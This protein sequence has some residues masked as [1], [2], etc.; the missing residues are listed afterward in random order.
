MPTAT[1][2]IEID[3]PP[4]QVMSVITDFDSY[5]EFL[6]EMEAIHVLRAEPPEWEVRFTVRVI[7]Q[8]VYTLHLVQDDP[9]RLRWSMIEGV[10]RANDGGW[11]L[12][13]LDEGRR[14]HATY[15]IDLKVGVYVPANIVHSLV[16]RSLPDTLVR[17]R[18]EAARRAA[19]TSG[20]A[21]SGSARCG[22]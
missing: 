8:L 6:P 11:T 18:D 12:A 15:D 7:R 3:V 19:V 22:D 13:P 1:R 16:N 2:T 5:P 4:E 9:L 17:F 21:P 10:F 20:R 14:T